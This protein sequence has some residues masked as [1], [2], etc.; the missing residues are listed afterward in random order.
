MAGDVA[1]HIGDSLR[2]TRA[3]RR[4]GT[5]RWTCWRHRPEARAR[6]GSYRECAARSQPVH[7]LISA[8][9]L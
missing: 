8:D 3:Q 9:R 1:G 2:G 7:V 4:V 5:S 6:H